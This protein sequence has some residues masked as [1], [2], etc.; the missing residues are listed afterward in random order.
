MYVHSLQRCVLNT[1]PFIQESTD[2]VVAKRNS[3]IT[4]ILLVIAVLVFS[5]VWVGAWI[6]VMYE[7][8]RVNY[9]RYG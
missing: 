7:L 9:L 2:Y 5:A 8:E 3:E 4:L 6:G 1:L